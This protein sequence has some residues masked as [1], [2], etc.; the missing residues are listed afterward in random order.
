MPKKSSAYILVFF[1]QITFLILKTYLTLFNF[2]RRR[3]AKLA[4]IRDGYTSD[5]EVT[6][7]RD[8]V[9]GKQRRYPGDGYTSDMEGI[10]LTRNVPQNSACSLY[11]FSNYFQKNCVKTITTR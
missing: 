6:P 9:S 3:Q 1:Q 11:R 8:A 5:W 4:N 2:R 7:P 10:G